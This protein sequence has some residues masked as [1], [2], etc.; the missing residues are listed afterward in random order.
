VLRRAE[1]PLW[2]ELPLLLLVA[3]C[4]AVLVRTFVVQAFFIPSASM[5]QTLREGDRVLVD[6]VV[7]GLREPARGEVVV[8]HGTG[9]W[10]S[11]SGDG[12]ADFPAR[13]GH[14]LGD[15]AGEERPGRRDFIKRVVGVSGDR[16]SCCDPQG[17]VLV[18]GRPIDERYVF[19]DSSL[20]SPPDPAV[21]GSRRFTEVVVPPGQLWVM[22]DHRSRSSDARCRGPVPVADVVGR[23]VVVVWPRNRVAGLPVPPD[24]RQWD[25]AGPAAV[26]ARPPT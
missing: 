14:T 17:R 13:L 15:L 25:L 10:A 21:C 8:F 11:R 2:L 3:G 23:A 19:E 1:L 26:P 16:V 20:S 12:A 9:R 5:E 24:W 7:Y 4:L 6:K 18:N 22:G